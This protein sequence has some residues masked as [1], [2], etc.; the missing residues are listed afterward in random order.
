MAD[1]EEIIEG[2]EVQRKKERTKRRE[3]VK[4]CDA[5]STLAKE[6]MEIANAAMDD[7]PDGKQKDWAQAVKMALDKEKGG[8]WHVITGG[9]FGGN[10]TNDTATMVNFRLNETWFLVFRSGPPE[11]EKTSDE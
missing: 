4:D 8:T 5:P 1:E 6:I 10:V 2:E 11:K 9:H 7:I 3:L